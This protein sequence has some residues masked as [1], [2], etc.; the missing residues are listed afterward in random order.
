MSTA[1]GPGWLRRLTGYVLRHRR[2]VALALGAAVLGAA[3]QTVVPLLEREIVDNV[4][5]RGDQSLWPWLAALLVVAAAAFVFTYQRRYRG[6]RVALAVQYDLR[7]DMHAH[8]QRLD[9]AALDRMPTGQVVARATADS[10]IVQGLL[11]LLPTVS[12]NILLVLL[13]LTVMLVLSPL[14]ALVSLIVVPALLALSYRM[15]RRIFPATW[16]AQQRE[17][18][19]VQIVDEDI[20]GVRVV[21]AFGQ[22]Q[23]ELARVAKTAGDV[24]STN[25]RA[26]RLQ[27]RYQPL[28]QAIP[29]LGQVAVLVVGGWLA[30]H[31]GLSLGTFLA[32]STYVAQLM[33]PARQ[34]AGVLAIGQQARAGVERIFQLLDLEPA[35]TDAPDARDLP[36][37][38]GELT[39]R[40]VHFGHS[41]DA[42][43]LRG[44]ELHLAAGER[45]A[46]V[47]ASGSGKTTATMLVSRF[48]DPDSGAV[49]VDGHD[50]RSV[51]LSSLRSQVG[52]VFE[53]S[54]LF[55]DTIR[56][57][58]AYA[59]PD[60]G[61]D[62]ILAAA[63]IAAADGFVSELPQGYDTVVGERGL[64]LSGGQRQRIALARAVLADPR[65]L[66]LD[67][68]TSAVD[69]TTEEAIN[70]SLRTV[71]SGR[72]TLLVAHR[73]STLHLADRVVML[74]GGVVADQGSHEELFA[75]S[76]RYRA[77]LTG[78]DDAEA[79][80]VGDRIEA[81]SEWAGGTTE[82]AW[83]EAERQ[84]EHRLHTT[85]AST[86]GIGAGLAGSAGRSWR[87]ALPPT[88]ELLARV[89]RLPPVRDSATLDLSAESRQQR[90][91]S[92]LTLLREFRR[93]LA[94]GLLL[95]VL[96]A[97]A[98]V[99]GPVLVKSG[100]DDGVL[101]ASQA[102]LFGA[103]GL[104]LVII[105]AALLD[106]IAETFVTGRTTQRVMLSLRVRIWAQLQRLSLDYYERELTGRIMTRMTT[107]VDQFE[108]LIQNGLLSALVAVVTFAGVGVTLVVVNPVLG[109]CT[110]TVVVPL[111]IATAAFRRRATRLYDVARDRVAVVNADFQESLAGVRESQAFTHEGATIRRFRELGRDYLDAR[112]SAQR[113]AATYFPF[114]QFLSAG[115]DAIV[116]GVG[117]GMVRSG[118][119][120]AGAL[121]A[122]VLYI[123]LFFS[124][125]QQLSQ[126]FDS[127]LQTRVSV[128]RIA[129]LMRLETLTP[130]APGAVTPR[131]VRGAIALHGVRFSYP[132]A[133][134]TTPRRRGPADPRMIPGAE[135]TAKL[136][137]A[138]R[139]IDLTIAPGETVALVGE[140]GAGKSTVLKLL[141]RF[142]DPDT[143]H[144]RVDGRDLRDL[145]LAGYRRLL[146]YV[147]QEAFLFTG[148]VRDNIA[149]GRA[150]ATDAEVEAA[151]R[152]VGAH[153]FVASLPGGYLHEVAERG[154]S[155]S[156]GQRQ[157]LALARAQLVDPA[158]L[159]LD[160]ATSNLD[161][162]AE[163]RVSNAMRTVS[164]GRTTI[165]I[166]HRLHTARTA[167]R[168]VVLEHGRVAESGSHADLLDRPGRYAAMWAAF[169]SLSGEGPTAA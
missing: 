165:V 157:L 154:R 116:L 21:K 23:R 153:E 27:S 33:A 68:A 142:Y 28:L 141:A 114:V 9:F 11:T 169:T 45:V 125:V 105:L 117:A 65:I 101:R 89:D 88:P 47:G 17:G 129:E 63:R 69:A 146:G 12:G 38:R 53:E 16:A 113:L 37:A 122:F 137:E 20:N 93:P 118:S 152:A 73:R 6:G 162:A 145:D 64:S 133:P 158:I 106:G 35:I 115:A 78:L 143:G 13:S 108:A 39:F 81:L 25:L 26:V 94:L 168:I 14:L 102:V 55:S 166:A 163:A 62:E 124:P 126:V 48:H 58:I 139:G 83:R 140:T 44:F 56:A 85:R 1:D 74:D 144:V 2:E 100:I 148:T 159:L 66:V 52:V 40:D 121:I 77:L 31:H 54:F 131:R 10:G 123:D 135:A 42:P 104:F 130:V 30:L 103:A 24:Y 34:L 132:T 86:A 72:T 49:L 87:A 99:I 3:C 95:V 59:R 50:L 96:D 119:L 149:Y 127:W 147:P 82:S 112:F 155:L 167:D 84:H 75:R 156:A 138:L 80:Q 46:L 111:A 160:E 150:D 8:L 161:L 15:R 60:A 41:A 32:F 109:L 91:F 36:P 120:S 98:S 18:D 128:D 67:D 76:A 5:L 71:L 92:L 79:E 29:S 61:E 110:L 4:V 43:V 70:E 51:R 90:G 57:N 7:N 97:A 151:A 134:A 107:D 22:E 164:S 136:P 19:L